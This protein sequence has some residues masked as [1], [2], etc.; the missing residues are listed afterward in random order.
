MVGENAEKRLTLSKS[1]TR[2]L[3]WRHDVS[4]AS[5]EEFPLGSPVSLAVSYG[6]SLD[7]IGR[8]VGHTQIGTTQRYAHL[9]D[10]SLRAGVNAVGKMLKPRLRVVAEGE[11]ASTRSNVA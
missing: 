3:H 5:K 10:A 11:T 9:I 4:A 8:L 7:M 1:S 6:A 2:T